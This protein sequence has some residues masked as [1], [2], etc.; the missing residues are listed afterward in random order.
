MD[1]REFEEALRTALA[2]DD[3]P[4]E[5]VWAKVSKPE[6][7]WLPSWGELSLATLVGVVALGWMIVP[8]SP[9]ATGDIPMTTVAHHDSMDRTY[10]VST[11]MSTTFH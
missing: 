3:F 6:P 11:Q 1:E 2:P 10:L 9:S 5:R 7:R 8:H 4:S